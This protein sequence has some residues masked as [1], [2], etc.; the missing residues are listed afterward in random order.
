M[1]IAMCATFSCFWFTQNPLQ[2]YKTSVIN[3]QGMRNQYQAT[4]GVKI[5]RFEARE[6][7][8]VGLQLIQIIEI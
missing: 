4:I 3:I 1:T 7:I 6:S 2:Y 5:R 8:H